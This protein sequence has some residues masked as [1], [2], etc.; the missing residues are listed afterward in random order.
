MASAPLAH[1]R[2]ASLRRSNLDFK[3]ARS[4]DRL[5]FVREDRLQPILQ[6]VFRAPGIAA[7]ARFML[8]QARLLSQRRARPLPNEN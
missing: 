1:I 2:L 7:P 5:V 6:E 3:K 4:L 8:M